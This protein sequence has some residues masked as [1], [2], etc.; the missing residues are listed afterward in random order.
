ME[1][2]LWRIPYWHNLS[3]QRKVTGDVSIWIGNCKVESA[4][5]KEVSTVHVIFETG[6][7][8]DKTEGRLMGCGL[9]GLL[10]GPRER[11]MPR[12]MWTGAS[13]AE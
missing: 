8:S 13:G 7:L 9:R 11:T 6:I 1:F 5:G 10:N 4:H 12:S 2:D 3:M